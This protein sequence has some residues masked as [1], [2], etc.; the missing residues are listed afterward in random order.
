MIA[1]PGRREVVRNLDFSVRL[2]AC[3]ADMT[4]ARSQGGEEGARSA[5]RVGRCAVDAST[6]PVPQP[7]RHRP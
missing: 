1:D 6:T 5:A 7:I 2:R 3:I 4:A